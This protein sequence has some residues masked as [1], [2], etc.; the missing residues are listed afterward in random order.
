MDNN[1]L[2]AKSQI[3]SPAKV[4]GGNDTPLSGDKIR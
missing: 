4:K 3:N 2:I 1:S